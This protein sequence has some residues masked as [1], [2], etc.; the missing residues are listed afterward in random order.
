M[1]A[2]IGAWLLNGFLLPWLKDQGIALIKWLKNW[3]QKRQEKKK[4]KKETDKKLKDYQDA[5]TEDDI[6][7]SFGGM[8]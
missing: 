8:P 4:R 5:K 7:D 3:Y 6:R 2:K 1:W